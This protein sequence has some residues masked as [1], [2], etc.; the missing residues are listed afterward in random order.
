M[1]IILFYVALKCQSC[2][3]LPP[4]TWRPTPCSPLVVL[5]STDTCSSSSSVR[6][7]QD[8]RVPT[9]TSTPTPPLGQAPLDLGRDRATPASVRHGGGGETRGRETGRGAPTVSVSPPP[10]THTHT[11]C[12]HRH[13]HT[14]HVRMYMYRRTY[15]HARTHTPPSFYFPPASAFAFRSQ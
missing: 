7:L 9:G 13:R 11:H 10:Y 14:Q 12:T 2:T 1:M 3:S 15:T 4:L 6:S 8:V 5:L